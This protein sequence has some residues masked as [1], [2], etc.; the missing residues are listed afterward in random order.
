MQKIIFHLAITASILLAA[1]NI[2]AGEVSHR[3]AAA[4]FIQAIELENSLNDII[5]T[6][7]SIQVQ[8]NP[9]LSLYEDVIRQFLVKYLGAD[10][11]KDEFTA[12]YMEEFNEEE[13]RLFAEF[14][15]SPAGRKFNSKSSVLFQKGAMIGQQ[16]VEN[17]IGQL[18]QMIEAETLRLKALQDSTK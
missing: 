15:T 8:Q 7:L 17:N 10:N 11:L 16:Q 1:G 18:Q 5:D 2:H 4:D 9:Q 6:M 12:M 3:Q 14:F 13:L